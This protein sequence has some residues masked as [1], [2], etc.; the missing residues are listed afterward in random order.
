[1]AKN[2]VDF[3]GVFG[4]LRLSGI[5][6]GP[7]GMSGYLLSIHCLTIY[8]TAPL[9]SLFPVI[10]ALMSYW[11]LKENISKIAQFDSPWLLFLLRCLLL[12]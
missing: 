10:A 7:I 1:M 12:K 11:I 5:L 3:Q 8:Y 6:G 9:S 2:A 4:N